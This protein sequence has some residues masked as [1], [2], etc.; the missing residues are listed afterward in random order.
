M[1][2]VNG[3][4]LVA[5]AAFG[6]V[7][8]SWLV[9]APSH[10]DAP[11]LSQPSV[12]TI[13]TQWVRADAQGSQLAIDMTL[14]N[15]G[16]TPAK[17]TSLGYKVLLDGRPLAT[18]RQGTDFA[19]PAS[20]NV[21]VHFTVQIPG[22]L[23]SQWFPAYT[24]NLEHTS[25]RVT[26]T[27]N[28]TYAAKPAGSPSAALPTQ[29][30]RTIV[31]WEADASW[32]GHLGQQVAQHAK[33]CDQRTYGLCVEATR[34]TWSRGVLRL[35]MTVRNVGAQDVDAVQVSGGLGL[36]SVLVAQGTTPGKMVAFA[37]TSDVSLSLAFDQ[38]GVST[39]WP[40]HVTRCESSHAVLE[41]DFLDSYGQTDVH[42]FDLGTYESRFVCG[43]SV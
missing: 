36:G 11:A 23:S 28:L 8:A 29:A 43:R 25:L 27:V 35:E 21:P 34:A 5:V 32:D 40:D 18:G 1:A 13:R 10:S 2:F 37:G 31:P 33:D 4:L 7:A 38:A 26:G 30:S 6:V 12:T 20:A 9:L 16:D 41:V 17:A 22:D 15:P 42:L 3:V 19:V 14:R 24:A 39:W